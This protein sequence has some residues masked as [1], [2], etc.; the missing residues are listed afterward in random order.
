MTQDEI[1]VQSW[2]KCIYRAVPRSKFS[3]ISSVYLE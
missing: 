2:R 1:V 3:L